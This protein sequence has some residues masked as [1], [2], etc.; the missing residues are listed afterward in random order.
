MHNLNLKHLRYFWSVAKHGSVA[1]AAEN[2]FI[3]PQT[4]SG[5]I[6]DLEKQVG[7]KT[8]SARRQKPGYDR[9]RPTGFFIC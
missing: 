2:L 7:K 5:Q 4:I 9:N 8:V 1:K 6:S 3:T